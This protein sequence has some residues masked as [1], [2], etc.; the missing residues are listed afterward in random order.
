MKRF[1]Q[2]LKEE[3]TTGN[4]LYL[5]STGAGFSV[6]SVPTDFD[7]DDYENDEPEKKKKMNHEPERKKKMRPWEVEN[8]LYANERR[9]MV[10]RWLEAAGGGGEKSVTNNSLPLTPNWQSEVR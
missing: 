6:D 1:S 7:V 5:A 4:I 9:E 10:L 2:F 8:A 3:N